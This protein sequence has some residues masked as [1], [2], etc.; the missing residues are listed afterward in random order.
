MA[1]LAQQ[2]QVSEQLERINRRLARAA[3]A[4][5]ASGSGALGG[6]ARGGGAVPMGGGAMPMGGGAM[7]MGGGAPRGAPR[8]AL[9]T[10]P[11]AYD[12]AAYDSAIASY[13]SN[14][15]GTEA[16]VV[17]KVYKPEYPLKYGCNPQQKPAGILSG[18][19]K[20]VRAVGRASARAK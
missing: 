20:E 3:P 8:G 10:R 16:P 11:H 5:G 12:T 17:T 18:M 15:L 1:E 2:L 14:Q 4:R 9:A 19:G 13:F 7:P 6:G